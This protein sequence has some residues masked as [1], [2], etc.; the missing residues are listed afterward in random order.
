MVQAEMN[1]EMGIRA[2]KPRHQSVQKWPPVGWKKS[3]VLGI[4]RWGRLPL[5]SG[6]SAE[7]VSHRPL[8]FTAY[9]GIVR[10]GRLPIFW[11]LEL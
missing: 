8:G 5:T 7:I 1:L 6:S 11:F 10:W 9:L 4:V 3:T 2:S